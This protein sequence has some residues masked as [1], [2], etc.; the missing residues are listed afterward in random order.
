MEEESA[1]GLTHFNKSKRTGKR[2]RGSRRVQEKEG[3]IWIKRTN[4]DY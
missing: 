3:G 4:L 1:K 2:R